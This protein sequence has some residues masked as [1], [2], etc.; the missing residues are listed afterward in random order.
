VEA[1]REPHRPSRATF[2][3]IPFFCETF[4]QN[5]IQWDLIRRGESKNHQI[6]QVISEVLD[7]K[8]AAV[9]PP[10]VSSG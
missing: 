1:F 7:E 8:L 5:I 3:S 4:F 2:P 10:I 6:C 9:K